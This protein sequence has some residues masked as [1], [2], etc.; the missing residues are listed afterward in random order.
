[1][2]TQIRQRNGVSILEPSG[3]IVGASILGLWETL[4]PQIEAHDTPRILINF[5]KVNKI[6]SS[7]LGALLDARALTKRKKGR[8]GVINVG[9]N[10][11]NI[12]VMTRIVT[13]FEHFDNED[14]AVAAL[15]T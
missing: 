3:K 10:I 4:S 7:G 2:T 5:G 1:M 11:R 15:S 8:I 12:L 14:D 9:N 6:D 13:E